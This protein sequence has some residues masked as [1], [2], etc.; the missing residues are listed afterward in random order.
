VVHA[1]MSYVSSDTIGTTEE[2]IEVEGCVTQDESVAFV[3]TAMEC[4]CI[5][6]DRE[7]ESLRWG[8]NCKE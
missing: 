7:V 3:A 1:A 2:R 6:D 5:P 4:D 8:F